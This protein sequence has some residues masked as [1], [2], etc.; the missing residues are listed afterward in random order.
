MKKALV[1]LRE[2]LTLFQQMDG[3]QWCV[4]RLNHRTLKVDMQWSKSNSIW[5][6]LLKVSKR[7]LWVCGT[8]F[9]HISTNCVKEADVL[10]CFWLI[11][12][13]QQLQKLLPLW[14]TQSP[15]LSST[16]KRKQIFSSCR[17]SFIISV[18]RHNLTDVLW[19][20]YFL[21][22]P[23]DPTGDE[24]VSESEKPQSL[25]AAAK[26][27]AGVYRQLSEVRRQNSFRTSNE[28]VRNP[29]N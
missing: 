14:K 11:F 4:R 25:R 24:Q 8:T 18:K 13:E 23:A 21:V 27:S 28:F 7:N 9:Y 10:F 2:L 22:C 5:W 26:W 20:F 15:L 1:R 16:F 29:L 12:F 19:Q 6:L 3:K 17:R